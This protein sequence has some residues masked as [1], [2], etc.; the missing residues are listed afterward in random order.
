MKQKLQNIFFLFLLGTIGAKAQGPVITASGYN[1][2]IGD[3]YKVLNALVSSVNPPDSGGTDKVWDFSNLQDSSVN[4]AISFISTKGIPYVDSVKANIAYVDSSYAGGGYTLFNTDTTSWNFLGGANATGKSGTRVS[5]SQLILPYPMTFGIKY[6]DSTVYYDSKNIPDHI[7]KDT[8][9]EDAYGTL[10]LP[11]AVYKNVV[12][13]F[14][15]NTSSSYSDNMPY[16]HFKIYKFY[17]NGIHYPILQLYPNGLDLNNEPIWEAI[18]YKGAD[19]IVKPVGPVIT[20]AGYNPQIGDSYKFQPAKDISYSQ[21]FNGENKLWDFTNLIDSGTVIIN[22]WVSP[23]GLRYSDSFPTANIALLDKNGVDYFRVDSTIWG[24]LGSYYYTTTY[25]GNAYY[26][27]ATPVFPFMVYPMAMNVKY[28]DSTKVYYH[29]SANNITDIT[30]SYD[31]LTGIGYGNLKLPSGTYDSVVCVQYNGSY[32][33]IKNGVHFILLALSPVYDFNASSYVNGL[34]QASYYSGT[35]LP[36]QISSFT[37]SWQN[38]MPYLQWSATNT[39]STKAFNVQRSVDG[40]TFNNVGQVAASNT[41]TAFHFTDNVTPTSIVYYRLQ[42]VDKTGKFFYS[43]TLKLTINNYQL[44]IYPNPTKGSVRLSVPSG[45][46]VAVMVYNVVGKLV[47]EN[48][49]FT[50]IDVINTSNWSNGTYTIRTKDN[51]VWQVSSF[52]KE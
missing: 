1:P 50:S 14:Y 39:E 45:N 23:K 22:S 37:V 38:K 40:N 5:P 28:T 13:V 17:V 7:E 31:T 11:G 20:A 6:S 10:K 18:Y 51:N 12:R 15:E 47:Y 25:G 34:W 44:S 21:N 29:D 49:N 42:Q 4:Q 19:T 27:K 32:W 48:K 35:P 16:G 30:T 26:R 41:S 52:E 33:F 2:V 46:Q 3:R 24:E 8:L 9:F 43:N 36:L